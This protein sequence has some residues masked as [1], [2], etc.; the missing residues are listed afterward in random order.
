M[1]SAVLYPVVAA[2]LGDQELVDR[3][4]PATY[5]P[6]L[7]A[8]FNVLAERPIADGV[9][10]VTGAGAFLQQVVFGYTGLRLTETGLR[11]QFKPVLPAG[12]QRIVLR[13]VSLRGSRQDIIVD[14]ENVRFIARSEPMRLRPSSSFDDAEARVEVG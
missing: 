4:M 14:R 13:N 6:H 12:I 1:M 9:N 10:F 5:E 8:P 3:L 11:P 2:E 7:R